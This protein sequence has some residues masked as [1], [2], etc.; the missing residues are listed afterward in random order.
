MTKLNIP[1]DCT[2]C[3]FNL[4]NGI[5]KIPY[6]VKKNFP[7]LNLDVGCSNWK[8]SVLKFPR[9]N[10]ITQAIAV[11]KEKQDEQNR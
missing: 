5:K 9:N 6:C 4:P 10:A 1:E 2:T 7:I 8:G 3:A 11:A